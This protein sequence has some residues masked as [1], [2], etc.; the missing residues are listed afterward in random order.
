MPGLFSALNA[1]SE[2]LRA[3]ERALE[4]TQNN[5]GNASTPGFA[6]QVSQFQPL[7][8][9]PMDGPS[10]GVVFSGTQSLRDEYAERFVQ[11]QNSSLGS[12]DQLSA[13][14]SSLQGIFDLSGESGVSGAMN[15]LL[16][17]FSALSQNP[18]DASARQA[19]ILDAENLAAAFQGA[20]SAV[21]QASGDADQ[22]IDSVVSEINRIGA[23]LQSLNKQRLASPH[24]DPNLDASIHTALED[25]SELV[26]FTTSFSADGTVNVLIGGQSP[27]VLGANVY[28]LNAAAA[29]VSPAAPYPQAPPNRTIID[30]SGNDITGQIKSGRLGGA[31]EMR[32]SI[33]P[34]LV[35]SPDQA[36]SL[37]QLARAFVDRVNQLL[38]SGVTTA[39]GTS[40]AGLPLF[41][42]STSGDTS[43]ARTLSTTGIT[44]A[45][46]APVDPGPPLSAGGIA[47]AI[48]NLTTSS[49]P[50]DQI[51]GVSYTAYFG[52]I[53]SAFGRQLADADSAK[54][55]QTQAVAQ[56]RSL[57]SEASGVSLDE[58]AVNLMSFQKAYQA[59][60]RLISILNELTQTTIDI[61]R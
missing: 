59:T 33:V 35:G 61:L 17:S 38:T 49:N 28:P 23:N 27:L 43:V 26:N 56:A 25:L 1:S 48:G 34:G 52:Q 4:V 22:Q 30:A 7:P 3:F 14:L 8:F 54:T 32:N 50:A 31:L 6:A 47:A 16:S 13:A 60:S 40:V 10:G 24:P 11:Q 39:D 37:N 45:Q 55:I 29:T 51:N 15:D 53:A 19:V 42:Y 36:G 2:S 20:A 12:A 58:E 44:G 5:I 9:S 57:R 46:L 41:Q 18:S 21:T